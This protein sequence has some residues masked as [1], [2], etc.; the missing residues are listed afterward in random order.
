MDLSPDSSF[1]S[2]NFIIE[3][4][5]IH[6]KYLYK[7]RNRIDNIE[8]DLTIADLE[9]S[10]IDGKYEEY[11]DVD[12]N[13]FTFTNNDD[14]SKTSDYKDKNIENSPVLID[15][16]K[17]SRFFQTFFAT[18]YYIPTLKT[19][20]LNVNLIYLFDRLYFDDDY[21]FY[22]INHLFYKYPYQRIEQFLTRLFN[23]LYDK[24]LIHI[25]FEFSQYN[26]DDELPQPS[27]V[28]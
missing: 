17:D 2:Y 10:N 16:N 15:D 14:Y 18:E 11:D 6:Y 20:I 19:H 3:M 28:I 23:K 5:N 4:R 13:Y 21:N 25:K 12:L 26:E 9:N 27:R 7:N 8:R 22:Y 1:S 24:E